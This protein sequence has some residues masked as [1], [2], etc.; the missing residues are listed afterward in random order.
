MLS[1]EDN[2]RKAQEISFQLLDKIDAEN[3]VRAGRTEIQISADIGEMAQ[4]HFGIMRHWHNPTVRSGPNTLIAGTR[5]PLSERMVCEDDIVYVDLGP[6]LQQ[7]KG[8]VGRTFCLGNDPA[9]KAICDDTRVVFEEAKSLFRSNNEMKAKELFWHVRKLAKGR[10]WSH[11]SSIAGHQIGCDPDDYFDDRIS[12][13]NVTELLINADNEMKLNSTR[14]DGDRNLWV[15][16][17]HLVDENTRIGAFFEDL[18]N[19]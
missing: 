7:W 1:I 5:I 6:I 10:G 19:V 8:D 11:N 12:S 2:L 16:E 13:G 18:L 3:L 14:P 17:V 15:L 4:K 9:K